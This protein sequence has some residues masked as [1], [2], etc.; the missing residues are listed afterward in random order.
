[1]FIDR[2]V[3]SVKVGRMQEALAL[4]KA[5]DEMAKACRLCGSPAQQARQAA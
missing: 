5:V 1:M 2:R 4:A 3:F